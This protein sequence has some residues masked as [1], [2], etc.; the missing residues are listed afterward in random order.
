MFTLKSITWGLAFLFGFIA[1]PL[2]VLAV[3]SMAVFAVVTPAHAMSYVTPADS[4]PAAYLVNDAPYY[5]NVIASDGINEIQTDTV[6]PLPYVPLLAYPEG[7]EQGQKRHNKNNDTVSTNAPVVDKIV[8]V[9]KPVSMND[10]PT[11]SDDNPAPTSDEKV[12]PN[13][14][15]GNGPELGSNG[16]D[17][18]PN[19]NPHA[20]DND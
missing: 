18:D 5:G 11:V 3:V 16:N 10:A 14:G 9:D 7:N 8:P 2:F 17:L 6:A 12:H 13:N 19:V 15:I 1:K 4:Q 20:N